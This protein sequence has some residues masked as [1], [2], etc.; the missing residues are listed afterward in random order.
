MKKIIIGNKYYNFKLMNKLIDLFENSLRFNMALPNN[1]NGTKYD[2]V[3]LNHHVFGSLKKTID[4]NYNYY[5]KRFD[6]E[7]KKLEQFYIDVQKYKKIIFHPFHKKSI[8]P[9]YKFLESKKCNLKFEN[10]PRVGMQGIFIN[11]LNN[12]ICYVIGFSLKTGLSERHIINNKDLCNSAHHHEKSEIDIL[13][14]LHNNKFIDATLCMLCND[15]INNIVLDCE[16]IYPKLETLKLI[17]DNFNECY[18]KNYEKIKILDIIKNDKNLILI[19]NKNLIK[20]NKIT[21]L[22]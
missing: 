22:H 14:W 9:I 21:T 16:V 10:I 11:I 17:I 4:I 13:I 7:K 5:G 1:N 3:I 6:I 20:L 18:L 2:E 12:N 19:D 8:E 15:E